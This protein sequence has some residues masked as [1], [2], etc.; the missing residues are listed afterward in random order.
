MKVHS[1]ALTTKARVQRMVQG[2]VLDQR[3]STKT[4]FARVASELGIKESTVATYFYSKAKTGGGGGVVSGSKEAHKPSKKKVS[5]VTLSPLEKTAA[6]MLLTD[7]D[8]AARTFNPNFIQSA[9]SKLLA[10]LS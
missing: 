9:G 1:N 6:L 8:E 3:M 10:I 5:A 7:R 2:Y 4:A